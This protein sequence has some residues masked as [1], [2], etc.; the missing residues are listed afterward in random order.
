MAK[1]SCQ[2]SSLMD[3]FSSIASLYSSP[4]LPVHS[5]AQSM[6][7]FSGNISE[8]NSAK[9]STVQ[10]KLSR[11][12]I[13]SHQLAKKRKIRFNIIPFNKME[14]NNV[15]FQIEKKDKLKNKK[16]KQFYLVSEDNDEC[17]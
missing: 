4:L 14:E 1:N 8:L 7:P 2:E 5:S 9:I 15:S 3:Y 12:R 10:F 6:V 13:G 16:K 11:S 17:V